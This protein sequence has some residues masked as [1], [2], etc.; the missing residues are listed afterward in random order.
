MSV[1]LGLEIR[2]RAPIA[3]RARIGKFGSKIEKGDRA[4]SNSETFDL[5]AFPVRVLGIWDSQ[6]SP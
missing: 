3:L 6:S 4:A 1:E 2:S 5:F